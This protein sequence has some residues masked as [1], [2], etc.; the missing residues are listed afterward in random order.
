MPSFW[1]YIGNGKY[2]VGCTGQTVYVYDDA[3][4]ELARFR[5]LQYAYLPVFS[6]RG[7]CFAV[8]TTDGRL[9]VY[10][11]QTLTLIKKF[12][13]SKVDGSQD[14]GC[15]FSPDGGEFYNIERH[16]NSTITA[17][18][19]YDTSDFSLKKRI[20]DRDPDTVLS[21][22]EFGRDAAY[23]L[24][25]RRCATGN[26]YY[27]AK[28]IGDELREPFE[29]AAGRFAFYEAYLRLA[30]MGFTKKA[31]EWSWFSYHDFDLSEIEAQ[32]HTLG[33]LW[34]SAAEA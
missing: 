12:R 3:G 25:F 22:I 14:D 5:D 1:S 34:R 10:S 16:R 23:V 13:F 7:D 24:F 28:L 20:L 29:I 33:A 15:C 32:N 30:A 11:L 6:P 27:V 4:T 8:K 9:A 19:I 21:A 18:S 2:K 26:R 31:K 17:L